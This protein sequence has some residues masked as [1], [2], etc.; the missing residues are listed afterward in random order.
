MEEKMF[1]K[2][3]NRGLVNEEYQPVDFPQELITAL[4]DYCLQDD[5]IRSLEAKKEIAFDSVGMHEPIPTFIQ[6]EVIQY[7]SEYLR[8]YEE[9]GIDP[10][11]ENIDWDEV[12][13]QVLSGVK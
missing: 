12:I 6:D 2:L 13:E 4:H 7:V 9:W 10:D 5:H 3:L 8:D 11:D 1:R